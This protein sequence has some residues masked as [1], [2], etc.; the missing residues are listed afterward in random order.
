MIRL[1]A[2]AGLVLGLAACGK[3]AAP[4]APEAPAA[5]AAAAEP[6]A[7]MLPVLT[8]YSTR[9][10]DADAEVYAAF[11]EAAGVRIE[12]IDGAAADLFRQ[13]KS[14]NAASPAGVLI[15]TD[16]GTLLPFQEA[17]LLQPIGSDKV[18]GAIPPALRE[19]DNY[20]VGLSRR[21]RVVVFDPQVVSVDEVDTY[22]DLADP[23]LM[24]EICVRSGTSMANL[25]LLSELIIRNGADYAE[26][27]ARGVAANFARSPDGGDTA[28]IDAVVSGTCAVALVNHHY[29][30]RLTDGSAEDRLKAAKTQ[31][32]FPDQ[33]TTGT[34]LDVTAAA[35]AAGAPDTE[36]AVRFIEFLASPKG[37]TLLTARSK[38]VPVVRGTPMPSGMED[39]TGF[40][41]SDLPVSNLAAHLSE[42]E[43]LFRQTGWE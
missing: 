40:K 34:H 24:G 17:G 31:I 43:A 27:W 41:E 18:T 6:P 3:P 16:A 2:A 22:E 30:V 13:M 21:Y 15:A 20:W 28:Q 36:L 4:T 14:K 38:E 11:E 33:N 29:W 10:S 8:V 23:R 9:S 39:L 7:E 32:V 12:V 26:A 25:S 19:K 35:L 42:A 37:Q 1:V 5:P